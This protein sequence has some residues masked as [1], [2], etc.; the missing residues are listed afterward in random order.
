[1]GVIV[2]WLWICLE[3]GWIPSNV[4]GIS[5]ALACFRIDRY[6][7]QSDLEEGKLARLF[8]FLNAHHRMQQP[9]RDLVN[10]SEFEVT[11]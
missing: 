1:M 4:K 6:S 10:A 7:C 3:S 9:Q 2:L 5:R 8:F 11:V